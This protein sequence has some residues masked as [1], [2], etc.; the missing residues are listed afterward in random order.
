MSLILLLYFILLYVC[1]FWS[2][3]DNSTLANMLPGVVDSTVDLVLRLQGPERSDIAAATSSAGVDQSLDDQVL[4]SLP[5]RF[6]LIFNEK[7]KYK[8]S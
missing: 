8:Y 7:T 3:K 6:Q 2:S 4:A 5:G 1:S